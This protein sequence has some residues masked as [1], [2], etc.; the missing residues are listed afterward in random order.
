MGATG[1]T[2]T[3]GTN[4][5]LLFDI[6]NGTSNST[7]NSTNINHLPPE[8]KLEICKHLD[9]TSIKQLRLT[10]RTISQLVGVDTIK[11]KIQLEKKVAREFLERFSFLQ[12]EEN[13]PSFVVAQ[14]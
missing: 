5:N 11:K 6:M 8:M 12:N 4:F 3:T 1:T 13:I 2:G 9:S 7:S 14:T 10:D